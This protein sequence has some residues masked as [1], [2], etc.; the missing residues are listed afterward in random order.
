MLSACTQSVLLHI[1]ESMHTALLMLQE[2]RPPLHSGR[3]AT[4]GAGCC[5]GRDQSVRRAQQCKAQYRWQQQQRHSMRAA[6]QCCRDS[7]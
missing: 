3:L 5:D 6:V 4:G 7:A 1:N 2:H